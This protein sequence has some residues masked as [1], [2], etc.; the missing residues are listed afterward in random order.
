M[1]LEDLETTLAERGW[2]AIE[3]PDPRP[4]FTVRDQLL[5][6]L[7]EESFPELASLDEYHLHATEEQA[8]IGALHK[9]SQYYWENRLGHTIITANLPLFRRLVGNDLHVQ[10]SPY[11]RAVRPNIPKD[12]APIHRDTYYGASAYEVSVFVPFTEIEK[13][14]AMRVV[15]G[16]HLEPDSAYPFEQH[17]SPDVIIRSPK[18]QLGF[19]YAPKL[20]EASLMERAEPV[21]LQVGQ[22]LIFGLSLVHGGGIN[23]GARTRFSSDIRVVNSL[24]PV[25]LSRGVNK[26]YFVPLCS[27]AISR[28]ARSYQAANQETTG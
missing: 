12:A 20:L 11:L 16:S 18:H 24:A 15:S 13:T 14:G 2:L 27:T 5:A 26:D 7:R 1:N 23:T 22:A 21:P 10:G 4:V 28:T 3:L 25:A 19:P 6:R 9:L 8:H 17:Q